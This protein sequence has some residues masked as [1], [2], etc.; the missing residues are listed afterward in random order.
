MEKF[1][2]RYDIEVSVT[3]P[4]KAEAEQLVMQFNPA[5]PDGMVVEWMEQVEPSGETE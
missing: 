4:S 2:F 1:T 5:L 3:A